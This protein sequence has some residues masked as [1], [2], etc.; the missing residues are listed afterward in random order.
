MNKYAIIH[1][2]MLTHQYAGKSSKKNQ[3]CVILKKETERD[4]NYKCVLPQN[5]I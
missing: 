1:S 3:S 4:W 2:R 5:K